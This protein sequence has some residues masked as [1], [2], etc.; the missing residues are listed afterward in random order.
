MS[1]LPAEQ[2]FFPEFDETL[3]Q[4][5]KE[6]KFV[7]TGAFVSRDEELCRAVCTDLLNGVGRRVIATRYG[8]SRNTVNAIREVM[9]SRG[10][11][12]PLKKEIARRLDRCV[13]YS[14]ENLEEAL[15]DN[16][17]A[18]GSL[19][20]AAAVLL[21]KKAALEGQPTARIEHITNR[22]ITHEEINAWLDTLPSAN[23]KILA[24][25][26]P[27][28]SASAVPPAQLPA[29]QAPKEDSDG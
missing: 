13:I 21:D 1:L 26:G 20:I 22:K 4:V 24:E 2:T 29:P 12:E 17:I 27:V 10:E 28:D 3:V 16:D 5:A 14:L 9:E 8:I 18:P 25:N 7:H 19:P 11:L 15:A 23:P 6:K